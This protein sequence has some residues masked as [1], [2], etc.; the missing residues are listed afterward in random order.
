M[1]GSSCVKDGYAPHVS[2]IQA[3]ALP[4]G[5]QMLLQKLIRQ[6]TRFASDYE[7]GNWTILSVKSGGPVVNDPRGYT[8]RWYVTFDDGTGSRVTLSVNFNPD[9]GPNDDPWDMQRAKF[10]SIQQDPGKWGK[11]GSARNVDWYDP[12]ASENPGDEA[13]QSFFSKLFAPPEG[14]EPSLEDASIV[15]DLAE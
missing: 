10:S 8:Q 15:D 13:D 2:P 4:I 6:N 3:A 7:S 9:A 14:D 5:S 12:G 11:N 1:K